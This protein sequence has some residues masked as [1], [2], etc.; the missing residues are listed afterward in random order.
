MQAKTLAIV[1]IIVI[2]VV[3]VSAVAVVSLVG[4]SNERGTAL[5][6]IFAFAGPIITALLLF[7][8]RKDVGP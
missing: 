8:N 3:S 7:L 1:A 4:N 2:T 5:T 6:A